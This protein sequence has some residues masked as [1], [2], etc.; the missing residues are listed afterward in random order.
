[1]VGATLAP[2]GMRLLLGREPR[3]DFIVKRGAV[4]AKDWALLQLWLHAQ[5][6]LS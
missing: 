5:D 6:L 3:L 1:V 4:S 2:G